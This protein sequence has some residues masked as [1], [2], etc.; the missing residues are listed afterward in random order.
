MRLSKGLRQYWFE[1]G[2]D[3]IRM[4]DRLVAAG[5]P[6]RLYPH[7]DRVDIDMGENDDIGI[8]LKSY[9][10]PELLAEL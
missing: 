8:D 9:T 7:R 2:I 1:P 4:F 5:L 6:A 10:S 3:E